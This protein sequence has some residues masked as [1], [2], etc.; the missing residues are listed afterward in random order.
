MRNKRGDIVAYGL[1]DLDDIDKIKPYKWRHY[2]GKTTE[3]VYGSKDGV[4]YHK[5]H[6][7]IMNPPDD[8]VV[9]HRN[10]NGL[11]N[12]KQNL[13]VCTQKENMQNLRNKSNERGDK[14]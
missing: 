4:G 5:L 7:V 10:H 13:K 2:K 6:R 1:I 11:D 9:D 8:L 3:Y 12:R 14:L